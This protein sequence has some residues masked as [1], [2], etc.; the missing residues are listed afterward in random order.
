MSRAAESPPS[1][2]DLPLSARLVYKVLEVEDGG[3]LYFDEITEAGRLAD[4]TARKGIRRLSEAGFIARN[5][6]GNGDSRYV[7]Y[8]LTEASDE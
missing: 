3:P 4:I 1:L 5:P 6:S 8:S 2:K 7:R